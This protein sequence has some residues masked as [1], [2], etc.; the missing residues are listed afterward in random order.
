M[1]N[2]NKLLEALKNNEYIKSFK[3][4]SE[5]F[6]DFIGGSTRATSNLM[7]GSNDEALLASGITA[8]SPLARILTKPGRMGADFAEL[9]IDPKWSLKN[10]KIGLTKDAIILNLLLGNDEESNVDEELD[11]YEQY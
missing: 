2:I 3:P 8:A 11:N 1:N 9:L 5:D 6:A 7:G 4:T 10:N